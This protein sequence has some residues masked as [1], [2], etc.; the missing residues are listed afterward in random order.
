[1]KVVIHNDGRK[2]QGS[3]RQ[4]VILAEGLVERGHEVVVSCLAG[5]GLERALRDRDIRTT[6]IRPKGDAHLPAAFRFFLFLRRERPDVLL[7]TSWPR[8]FWATLAGRWAGVRRLVG[9]LG[10]TRPAPRRWKYRAAF[11]R[12][13][14]VIANS[15]DVRDTFVA[16]APEVPAGAVHVVRNAVV[17][18]EDGDGG[19]RRELG[20]DPE[21]VLILSVGS[22][23][24]RKG[25]DLLLEA[26][27]G[28]P[29]PHLAIAG[30]GPQD[31]ALRSLAAEL[32]L[33][34]RVHF[35][36]RRAD[37]PALLADADLFV[38]ATRKDSLPNAMLEA[39]AASVPVLV[40]TVGGVRR[41][42][43]AREDCPAAGWMVEPGSAAALRNALATA[44]RECRGEVGRARA[45][46][47]AR[48]AREWFGAGRMVEEAEAVLAGRAGPA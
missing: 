34:D 5:G 40:S 13:D 24:P 48:R 42:L 20:L 9:R 18:A 15:E 11:A 25:F 33:T 38:L 46:E 12:L 14:A 3:E 45:R 39:M 22:L 41:A 30:R 26:L 28:V 29:G 37:V 1:M 35:L 43:D 27:A 17:P 16:S 19:L 6:R 32:G 36:G 31:G 21:P 47:A 7:C 8:L 44:V 2:L 10:I 4:L 23:V